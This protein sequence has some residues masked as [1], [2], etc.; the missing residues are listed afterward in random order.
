[1]TMY[2]LNVHVCLTIKLNS[3]SESEM[4]VY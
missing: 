3:L 2:I 4:K 1:M